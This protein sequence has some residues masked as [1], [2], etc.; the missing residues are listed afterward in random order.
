MLGLPL[1]IILGTP[2]YFHEILA[3]HSNLTCIDV[4]VIITVERNEDAISGT[5]HL[6]LQKWAGWTEGS[7]VIVQLDNGPVV[8]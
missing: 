3:Q 7:L 1:W 5:W 6:L 2:G 4:Y 8:K